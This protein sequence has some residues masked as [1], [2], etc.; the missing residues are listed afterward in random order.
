MRKIK[1]SQ[2]ILFNL[3]GKRP[4]VLRAHSQFGAEI[5][6]FRW[7]K[8]FTPNV[9]MVRRDRPPGGAERRKSGTFLQIPC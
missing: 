8:E 6:C 2:R 3:I 5:P 7:S 4:N 1:E 9:L